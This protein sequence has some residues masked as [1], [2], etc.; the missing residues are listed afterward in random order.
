VKILSL[1][2]VVAG[3]LCPALALPGGEA[4]ASQTGR[5]PQPCLVKEPSTVVDSEVVALGSRFDAGRRNGEK[6]Q[7]GGNVTDIVLVRN[8]TD[9]PVRLQ[10]GFG[11]EIIE[12]PPRGSYSGH[13]WVPWAVDPYAAHLQVQFQGRPYF[14]IWQMSGRLAFQSDARFRRVVDLGGEQYRQQ[15]NMSPN[16]PGI[17]AEGGPR[18]LHIAV[19][20]DGTPFFKVEGVAEE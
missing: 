13:M 1:V 18:A 4:Q 20:A 12:V 14:Y 9:C 16:V 7:I 6:L 10:L 17:A 8:H 3:A 11:S 2:L 19:T 15:Y 5:R